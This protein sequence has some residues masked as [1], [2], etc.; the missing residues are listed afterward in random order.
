MN[1]F[2]EPLATA[3]SFAR[4]QLVLDLVDSRQIRV[5]LAYYPTLLHATKAQRDSWEML[6]GG[7]G[8]H[9]EELDLDLPVIGILEGRPERLFRPEVRK[10]WGQRQLPKP[11]SARRSK[12]AAG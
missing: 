5:P 3:L 4:D 12:R 2:N 6:G 1:T 7:V 11:E 8:F 9:W 10:K